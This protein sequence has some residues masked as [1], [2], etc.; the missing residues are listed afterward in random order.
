MH[1]WLRWSAGRRG[2]GLHH[3]V[4]GVVGTKVKQRA[5]AEPVHADQALATG[6]DQPAW[7]CFQHASV[8]DSAQPCP[9][10]LLTLPS[11][12]AARQKPTWRRGSDSR[13]AAALPRELACTTTTAAAC[14]HSLAAARSAP[15]LS[16]C[17]ACASA[18]AVWRSMRLRTDRGRLA[19]G[20]HECRHRETR[21]DAHWASQTDAAAAATDDVPPLL[22]HELL[23][24]RVQERS[25]GRVR[26][27]SSRT[28]SARL[29]G[30][31]DNCRRLR[32]QVRIP[33]PQPPLHSTAE[34]T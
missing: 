26:H 31:H 10:E 12:R 24:Q 2:P 32:Q 3:G 17:P 18:E 19:A 5:T 8:P 13:A 23:P 9:T 15:A 27:E 25:H 22:H 16:P 6:W 28:R 30:C 4:A 14:L 1:A 11:L 21:L 29:Q 33:P 34:A 20:L 7:Q